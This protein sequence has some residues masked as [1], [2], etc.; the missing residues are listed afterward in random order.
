MDKN[1]LTH[2]TLSG[3]IWKSTSVVI[4]VLLKTL[5]LVILARL[6]TPDDFGVVAIA[7]IFVGFAD[8]ISSLGIGPA[9][10]QRETL[11]AIHVRVGYTISLMLGVFIFV[12]LAISAPLIAFFFH[13]NL[14]TSVLRVISVTFFINSFG[15]VSESLL[16]RNLQFKTLMYIDALSYGIGYAIISV[17]LAWRGYGYWSLVAGLLGQTTLKTIMLIFLNRPLLI[18]MLKR[19]ELND[20]LSFGTGFTIGRFFNY[21]AGQGDYM[22]VGRVMD[23]SALGLYSRAYQI[24]VTPAQTLGL[25]FDQVLFS[26]MSKIQTDKKRL[27]QVYFR[28]V[29]IVS[30][31]TIPLAVYFYLLAPE[32]INVMLGPNWEAAVAPL[33]VLSLGLFFRTSY[34]I[35]DSISRATGAVYKRAGYQAI[36]AI[37]VVFGAWIGSHW[38]LTGVAFGVLVALLI[39]YLL[40]AKLSLSLIASN[41]KDF[42]LEQIHGF[43]IAIIVFAILL[44]LMNLLNYWKFSALVTLIVSGVIIA[45]LLL[46]MFL[47][48]P[49]TVGKQGQWAIMQLLSFFPWENQLQ[50]KLINRLKL[51]L[52]SEAQGLIDS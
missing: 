11:S 30:L 20:L 9:I 33:R 23:S 28:G 44:P 2:K 45:T 36:Y 21:F 50:H 27:Q 14:V 31:A 48:F 52:K 49:Q 19:Q 3:M 6:L 42:F 24:M 10:V 40:M 7:M 37:C 18:P 5:V 4:Q 13:N 35:S 32:I 41:W 43:F 47:I 25:V 16:W 17:V 26:S 15:V 51:S 1:N 38:N 8:M 22:V 34:K 46:S 29:A 12:V 39:V